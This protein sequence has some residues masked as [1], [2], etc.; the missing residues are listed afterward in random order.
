MDYII[1]GNVMIDTVRFPDGRSSDG[2][3]IGGPATFAYS[4][5][6]LWTD[7][8][9]QCSNVG[10]D[11]HRLFD[12]W[13]EKNRVIP[14]GIKVKVEHCNHSFLVFRED[15]TYG[16]DGERERFRDDWIQDFGYMKTS[17]EEIGEWTSKGRVKGVYIAQNVDR[18]FWKKMKALKA[19]DGF[20]L[21]WE[22]EGPS[23]YSRYLG[24]VMEA[25]EQTDIFSINI[26]EARNLFAV[27]SE[28]E[29]IAKLQ[30]LPVDMTLFR[31]GGK[32]L[33]SVT[34]TK[35]YYLPPAPSE[36]II[37]PTGCG[38]CST[39]SALYAYAEGYDP[40]MV[41]IMANVASAQ[42]IRQF[43]IMP[44]ILGVREAA[45]SQA[46]EL[47]AY[48]KNKFSLEESQHDTR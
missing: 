16:Q 17:P 32:G 5:V 4:G 38:N 11:Y 47:Y 37:D 25:L 45:R 42:N 7:S 39:G 21:M 23:A 44:D 14:D 22:I 15:G 48:Y 8:V 3:H 31:V 33:Y 27:E 40:L 43:G 13:M 41:G 28:A 20:K 24:P 12:P 18:V 1:A 34:P 36:A 35:A 46:E 9:M 30:T 6:K 26:Q 29:C 10:E 19:R 2:D